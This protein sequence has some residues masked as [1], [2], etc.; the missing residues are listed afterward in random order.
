V[1]VTLLSQALAAEPEE[2][3]APTPV[4][5]HSDTDT[6]RGLDASAAE[7]AHL[8]RLGVFAGAS[9]LTGGAMMA[10]AWDD[11]G[12]RNFAVQSVA[13]AGV[14]AVIVGAAWKG[15]G[16]VKSPAEIA[17]TREVLQLNV[18]LDAGY[19]M[20]GATM[21]V[22]GRHQDMPGLEGAGWGIVAQGL[23][24]LVLDVIV[25]RQMPRAVD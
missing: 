25:L 5:A 12:A 16:R 6:E 20:A 13:W 15:A 4:A 17:A 2:E 14:D 22:L 23:G 3:A 21:G 8:T 24:L 18:G 7:R 19:V 9:A 10:V 1:I 11:P